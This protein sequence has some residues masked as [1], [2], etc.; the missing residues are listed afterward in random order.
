MICKKSGVSFE[1]IPYTDY[2]T[3]RHVRQF[4]MPNINATSLL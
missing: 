4:E 2:S 3:A 1:D